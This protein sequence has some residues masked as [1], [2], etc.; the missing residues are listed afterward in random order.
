MA[1]QSYRESEESG[2]VEEFEEEVDEDEEG[3]YVLAGCA[4]PSGRSGMAVYGR[5]R[6]HCESRRSRGCEPVEQWD[7]VDVAH[8]CDLGMGAR[9]DAGECGFD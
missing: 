1:E 3:R 9:G 8:S 4:D 2:V 6:V 5:E 7:A